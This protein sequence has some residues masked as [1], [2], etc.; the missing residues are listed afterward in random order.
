MLSRVLLHVI[1][2][3]FGIDHAANARSLLK[4]RR[5]LQQMKNRTIFLFS[6]IDYAQLRITVA[7]MN[8]TGIKHLA[9]AGRIKRRTI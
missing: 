4:G 2:P 5:A 9:T 3:P 6:D 7:G 1:K 8:P